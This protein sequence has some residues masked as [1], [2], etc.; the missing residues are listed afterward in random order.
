MQNDTPL[1]PMVTIIFEGQENTVPGVC[2]E[3][4]MEIDGRRDVQ[5]CIVT[6]KDGMVVNRQYPPRE[7]K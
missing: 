5:S 7:A 3:C 4:L 6:V 1:S 2:Y